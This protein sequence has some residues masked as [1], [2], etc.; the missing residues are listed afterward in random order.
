[1]LGENKGDEENGEGGNKDQKGRENYKEEDQH[2]NKEDQ[3]LIQ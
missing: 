1:V 2:I 3:K